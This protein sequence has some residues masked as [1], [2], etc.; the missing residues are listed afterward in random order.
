MDQSFKHKTID[1]MKQ[2][3]DYAKTLPC[4]AVEFDI[5]A[6]NK[7]IEEY[8]AASVSGTDWNGNNLSDDEIQD[9]IY[10]EIKRFHD[11]KGYNECGVSTLT[12]NKNFTLSS[13]LFHDIYEIVSGNCKS[14]PK[15]YKF[16]G[17]MKLR[18]F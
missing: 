5:I 8:I 17:E 11:S 15:E 14:M 16:V 10:N 2:L 9:D 3:L 13:I 18:E 1:I 4:F 12:I 6:D 7:F